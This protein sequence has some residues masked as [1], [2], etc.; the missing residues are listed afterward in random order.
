[1]KAL[2]TVVIPTHNYGQYITETLDSVL[3]Q[4]YK[5]IEIIVFDDGS[6]DKTR[7]IVKPYVEQ[8]E[9]V[10]YIYTTHQGNMTPARVQN[11]AIRLAKG[12][13]VTCIGADDK[14]RSTYIERCVRE[15]SKSS[16]IGFVWTGKQEFG[17]SD[18]VYLPRKVRFRTSLYGG[19]D[20]ALGTML[21]R[22]EVYGKMPYDER[23][24]AREDWDLAL[25]LVRRGWKWRTINEPLY[26]QRVH[27]QSLTMRGKNYPDE[28]EGKYP[29][30]RP[31]LLW[32]QFI[33]VYSLFLQN[34][35]GLTGKL[36]HRLGLS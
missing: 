11:L 4:T 10:S 19:V 32:H 26:L 20:G 5:P 34:P 29:I 12:K 14:L 22:R 35:K 6:T 9:N 16:R 30:M 15:I 36:T 31:F 24:H 7:E 33:R 8:Y 1:M 2:V 18:K 25:A 27:S 21:V 17:S 28:L 3:A 23:L 13:Y